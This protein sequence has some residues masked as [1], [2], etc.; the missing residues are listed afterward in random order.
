M[1]IKSRLYGPNMKGRKTCSRSQWGNV[2]PCGRGFALSRTVELQQFLHC[3]DLSLKV[4]RDDL[5]RGIKVFQ[6]ATT[7][8]GAPS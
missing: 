4:G 7:R 2:E 8:M 1:R 5:R 6:P 3:A